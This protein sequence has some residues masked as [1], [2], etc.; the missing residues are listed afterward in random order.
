M[1]REAEKRRV[2]TRVIEEQSRLRETVK[3][4]ASHTTGRREGH[5]LYKSSDTIKKQ[6]RVV[7]THTY[8]HSRETRGGC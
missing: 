2:I 6:Q 3:H 1:R 7:N 4:F 5:I 8:T